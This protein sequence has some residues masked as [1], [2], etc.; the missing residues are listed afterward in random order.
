MGAILC[1]SFRSGDFI[2]EYGLPQHL[3]IMT[4]KVLGYLKCIKHLRF[5]FTLKKTSGIGTVKIIRMFAV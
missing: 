4:F 5:G 3:H 1:L 2:L